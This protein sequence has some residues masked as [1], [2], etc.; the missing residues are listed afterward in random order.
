MFTGSAALA[1]NGKPAT[2]LAASAPAAF[3]KSRRCRNTPRGLSFFATWRPQ[4]R[5]EWFAEYFRALS[6]ASSSHPFSRCFFI[7]YT[8]LFSLRQCSLMGA[9]RH[10][11]FR[12]GHKDTPPQAVAAQYRDNGLGRAQVA[13]KARAATSHR[14]QNRDESRRRHR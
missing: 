4:A 3:R 14:R 7:L 6:I 13:V 12:H 5:S 8:I 9:T 1:R 2:T 10:L 11:R